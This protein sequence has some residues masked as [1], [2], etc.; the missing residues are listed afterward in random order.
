MDATFRAFL[1]FLGLLIGLAT[2]VHALGLPSGTSGNN[3]IAL[4]SLLFTV[5]NLVYF[6]DFWLIAIEDR[7]DSRGG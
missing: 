7:H 2:L 3:F 4:G 6:V 1:H 5:V